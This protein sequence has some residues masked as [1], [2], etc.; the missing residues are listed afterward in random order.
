MERCEMGLSMVS[1]RHTTRVHGPEGMARS[2]RG[3]GG[4]GKSGLGDGGLGNGGLGNGDLG[5]GNL[6][7]RRLTGGPSALVTDMWGWS[8][9][10]VDWSTV[11][12][13]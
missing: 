3:H 6:W 8:I 13:D 11:N 4:L 7:Q 9:V 12:S 1:V 10:I 2:R 5:N